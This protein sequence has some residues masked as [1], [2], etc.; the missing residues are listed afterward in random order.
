VAKLCVF[1]RERECCAYQWTQSYQMWIDNS[2]VKWLTEHCC[3]R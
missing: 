1:A 2:C 3:C